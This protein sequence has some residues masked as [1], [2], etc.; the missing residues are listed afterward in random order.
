[1]T[2]FAMFA[3]I[4]A[5]CLFSFCLLPPAVA[6]A[7]PLR[8][9][10]TSPEENTVLKTLRPG[11]PR[12]LL[13][14]D[15]FTR[16][17]ALVTSDATA[18]RYFARLRQEGEKVLNA[19][20]VEYKLE[21]P[22]LL[23]QS[24]R[25]LER[26]YLLATLHRLDGDAKW[27][28]RAKK[29]L[30]AAAAFPDWNPSHFLDTAEMT[31]AFA[32]GYDWLHDALSP[33]DKAVL[34]AAMVEKGLRRGEEAY[35]GTKPWKWW[36]RAHHNWNQVCNGGLIMGA[37][38]LADEE[39][40]LAA[41]IVSSALKSLPLAMASFAPDGG[42]NEGPGYWGYTVAY[43]VP[44]LAALESSLGTDFG[45]SQ[46]AGFARTGDFR[47]AFTGP[48]GRTFN[49]A[50]AGD[51]AG[52]FPALLWLARRFEQ[53]LYAD[54]E[55]RL[56]SGRNPLDLLW[57]QPTTGAADGKQASPKA[58]GPKAIGAPLDTFFK[59][60]DVAFLRSAWEDPNA[61]WLGFKGGDNAA[62]HSHLDLGTF[63]FEALGER[64]AVELGGDNYNLPGYFGK[65]RWTY[66]RL[67]TE[68]Q[69]T[70]LLD[71][72]N[73]NLKARAP[74]QAFLSRPDRSFVVADLSAANS[75]T[76]AGRG[77]ARRGMALTPG[78]RALLVQDE[79]ESD[80]P[81]EYVWMMHT[82]AAIEIGAKGDSATLTQNGKTVDV[83]V[84]EPAGAVLSEE[85]AQPPAPQ[86]ANQ[87][88]RK[89]AVR[90]PAKTTAARVAV[91]L[92]PRQTAA[93]GA[94]STV[95][96]VAVRPLD[97]WLQEAGPLPAS[98]PPLPKATSKSV[99]K[100]NT[101]GNK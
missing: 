44:L 73:Q 63:V 34:R 56:A 60:V 77:R 97:A 43:T 8:A 90:L 22:R 12:L 61:L 65:D 27:A 1:M 76:T 54:E 23:T 68:G 94:N 45:V 49:Y 33:E 26:V 21:G 75:Q 5:A 47:L 46:A 9:P 71:G 42:W 96:P 15:D 11:H 2:R 14:G 50:D 70:F 72:A 6:S 48:T 85:S 69:N 82:R 93:A 53:P 35:R 55:R 10:M 92:A 39:P 29:E 24:R 87:G 58:S 67:R 17:K 81:V 31:H 100:S 30:F 79:I 3:P 20:P 16:V 37:L 38:A 64:W 18:R 13:N 28:A 91:L 99:S 88:V 25:C 59:G 32:I 41:F 66:Y 62:N 98:G 51:G 40:Q 78:R 101:R 4:T 95:L 84:L 57:Y 19:P 74:L 52:E 80:T 86:N 89:L 83:R 36:V 7:A